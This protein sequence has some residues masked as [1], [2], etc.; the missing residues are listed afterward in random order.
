MRRRGLATSSIAL[1]VAGLGHAAAQSAD[2]EATA[3]GR[4][5]PAIQLGYGALPG[6][7]HAPSART[8]PQ[9]MVAVT[10][11]SGFGYRTDLLGPDHRFVRGIGNLAFAYAPHA[12]LTLAL[13]LDGRYDRHFGLAPTGDDGYV[14]DPR[15][16]V[17]AGRASGKLTLGGQ[18]TLWVPGKDAPSVAASAISVDARGLLTIEAGAG[19]VS[20]AAGFRLDNSGEAVEA[21]EKLSPQDR[22]SLGV[23]DFHAVVGGVH[24]EAAVG[25]KSFVGVEAS[26]DLFVGDGA[27]GPILRAGLH[28]GLHLT[29]QWSVLAY[30][31][32]AKVPGLAQGDITAGSIAQIPYE[33]IVTGGL[34]LQARFGGPQRTAAGTI[35]RNERPAQIEVIE[36]A[37]VTGSISD[38]HGKPVVGAR[39]TVKLA[40]HTGTGVTDDKGTYRIERLPIGKT[41]D[42]QSTLDDTGAEVTIEV[43]QKKPIQQTLTLARGANTVPKLTL[44]P[45]LP[46]GQLRAVVRAA[47]SGKAI[48][49]ATV[50]RA[51]RPDVESGPDGSISLDLAPGKYKATATAAGFK[52]QTLDVTIETNGVAVKNFELAK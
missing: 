34:A 6:G 51:W 47:G 11:T 17:R 20:L 3:P 8:L 48:A 27:P 37:D 13:A 12:M 35:T 49:N 52:L 31:E 41:V 19:R 39:V 29:D 15:L 38:E 32:G 30:V 50:D 14:G 1:C 44:E 28:G 4:E 7:L 43:D 23:S 26:L 18:L 5:P 21:P 24:Y 22:V 9:G 36:Y 33:P 42:G 16:L 10:A 40:R 25:R 2:V 45:M 46:P